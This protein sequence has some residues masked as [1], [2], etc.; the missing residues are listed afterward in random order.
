LDSGVF[1][2]VTSDLNNLSYAQPYKG[3]DTVHI[4]NNKCLS[5]LY[6]GTS[7]IYIKFG[8]IQLHNVLHVS[9]LTTI[10]LSVP[11]L[12]KDDN[13]LIEFSHNACFI[14]DQVTQKI[15]LH[16]TLCNDLYV[17]HYSQ[18]S[19]HVFQ[20][21][22]SYPDIFHSI[23]MHCSNSLLSS[24]CKNKIISSLILYFFLLFGL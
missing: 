12:I 11:E 18:A 7:R 21:S 14:K 1:T 16:D 22:T 9:N 23:L 4:G 13:I 8:T 5:I 3:P 17:L 6:F 15:L 2:H 20:I 19:H 10:L 24:M